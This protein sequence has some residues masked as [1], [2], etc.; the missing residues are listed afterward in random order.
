MRRAAVDRVEVG[1]MYKVD[2]PVGL[3][4]LLGAGISVKE[5]S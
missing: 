3:F 1:N 2:F 4:D 5:V